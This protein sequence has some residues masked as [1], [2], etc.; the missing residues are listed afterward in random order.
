MTILALAYAKRICDSQPNCIDRMD[1]LKL[2]TNA[3][4]A[5]HNRANEEV[6]D[7]ASKAFCDKMNKES[8][9][10]KLSRQY[11]MVCRGTCPDYESFM[12]K[13]S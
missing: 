8:V 9:M 3:Y 1:V 5:G 4:R 12:D 7:K 10:C 6:K 13:L 11:D 2:V